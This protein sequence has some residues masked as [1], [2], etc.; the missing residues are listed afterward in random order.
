MLK[1][2]AYKNCSTCRNARK[3]LESK[4][5]EFEEL[6]IRETP[7]S[8]SELATM[9]KAYDGKMTRLFNTS[10]QDYRDAGLKDKLSSLSEDEA[11][12]L[13]QE[14]GNLVKRPFLLGDG[15]AL[16]GFKEAEWDEKL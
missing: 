14:N 6:A 13:L 5:V 15:V 1:F 16:V 7:P 4:G 12:A 2:Y 3:F 8:P 9:L 11:F 10:S